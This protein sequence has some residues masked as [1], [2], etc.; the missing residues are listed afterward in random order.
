[1]LFVLKNYYG[2]ELSSLWSP[3]WNPFWTFFFKHYDFGSILFFISAFKMCQFKSQVTHWKMLA[4]CEN[5]P[6]AYNQCFFCS[7]NPFESSLLSFYLRSGF[8]LRGWSL[9]I[10][11]MS[12][13][14]SLTL[15]EKMRFTICWHSSFHIHAKNCT[16]KNSPFLNASPS[17]K[18]NE[19][20]LWCA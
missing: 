1:M 13:V 8:K 20:F 17:I 6:V 2:N 19:I 5:A 11:C 9:S 7:I 15:L 10:L 12:D 14:M 16:S 4:K 18:C 3:K